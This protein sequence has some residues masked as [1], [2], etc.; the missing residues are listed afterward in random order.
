[1]NNILKVNKTAAAVEESNGG[2]Y[3]SKSGIYDV[4][5]KFASIDVSKGGAKSVNFNIDYNGNDQT[6]YGPYITNKKD[7][8]LEIGLKLVRDKLGAIADV[9]E[10]EIEQEEHA[11]GKDKT[12]K[13]FAVITNY[14]DLPV[15]IRLQEEYNKYN[16]EIRKRM[17]IKN[18]FREDGASAEEIINGTEVGK[19]LTIEEEKYASNI[20]YKD[21]L[22]PED[23]AAWIE[24]K[25][26]GASA[27][28]A[29][30]KVN[31]TA[32]SLFK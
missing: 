25:K 14:T 16:G 22:T 6:I 10:L 28:K 11:V 29:A 17:V 5:I 30:P 9:A 18:F 23:I 20:T 32:S 21:D 19:R 13:E 27:P 12:V 7:E 8:P 2:S 4:T 15:K 24:S 31:T 26:S 3:I 1:M